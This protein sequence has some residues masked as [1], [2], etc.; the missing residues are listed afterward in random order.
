MQPLISII[1][2]NYNCEKFIEATIQSVRNQ[3]YRNWEW[4]IIDDGSK[5][6]SIEII[7]SYCKLD[8]RIKLF[9][10][11]INQGPAKCRNKGIELAKG[12]F[13][14]FIDSDDIWLPEFLKTSLSFVKKSEGF[15]FASYHRYDENLQPKYRDFIVPLKVTYADILKTNSISCLTAFI[16]IEKLGKL[17]MPNVRYRQDMGLWLS[18]LKKIPYAIGNQTPLAIYRIRENSHSRNKLNL[19]KH[20]WQFYRKV[21]KLSVFKSAYYFVLWMIYGFIKY[22][23]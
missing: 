4:Y 5:D 22:A 20:Q 15:V 18:Y 2:P 12:N 9:K 11:A 21:E 6:K 10:S 7:E 8:S 14:T 17:Y 1:T 16:N 3:S 23:N 19:L 13:M